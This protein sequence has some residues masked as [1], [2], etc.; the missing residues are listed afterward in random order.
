MFQTYAL[1]Y[2]Q[3]NWPWKT[4]LFK[5]E[6][7]YVVGI[8]GDIQLIANLLD[9]L[10]YVRESK[11][12]MCQNFIDSAYIANKISELWHRRLGHLNNNAD[13]KFATKEKWPGHL[14]PGILKEKITK[15][16][17]KKY[18]FGCMWAMRV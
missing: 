2:C 16:N 13:V 5:K 10:Y 9:G 4:F 8:D 18:S 11:H 17:T 12:E 6:N 15:K 14:F 7:A 3:V 1:T